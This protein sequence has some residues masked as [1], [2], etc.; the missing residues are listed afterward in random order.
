MISDHAGRISPECCTVSTNAAER[1]RKPV[2][3]VTIVSFVIV[4]FVIVSFVIV[5]F[6]IVSFVTLSNESKIGERC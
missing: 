4:S 1:P 5:S 6:V 2:S 3:V